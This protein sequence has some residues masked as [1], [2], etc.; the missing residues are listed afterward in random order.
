MYCEREPNGVRISKRRS[1]WPLE[2]SQCVTIFA[3]IALNVFRFFRHFFDLSLTS[4]KLLIIKRLSMNSASS[5]WTRKRELYLS[6]ARLFIF[7]QRNSTHF[8]YL[9]STMAG[10]FLKR[11]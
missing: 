9:S 8:Y 4:W 1:A 5:Y 11:K 2:L 10:Y 7:R 6:A 3:W